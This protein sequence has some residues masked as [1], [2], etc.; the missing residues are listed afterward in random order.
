VHWMEERQRNKTD[1][2][3]RWLCVA[4]ST[5]NEGEPRG[6]STYYSAVIYVA[7]LCAKLKCRPH[8]GKD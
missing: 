5:G 8:E 3:F 7:Y 4:L 1:G 2:I 6:R